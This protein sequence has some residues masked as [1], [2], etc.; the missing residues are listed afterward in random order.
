MLTKVQLREWRG[1]Q[2]TEISLSPFTLL[3]GPNGAGKSS[4]LDALHLIWTY[5]GVDGRSGVGSNHCFGA[6]LK[7]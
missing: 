6:E 2:N 5:L 4:V 7:L 3:V 1:H